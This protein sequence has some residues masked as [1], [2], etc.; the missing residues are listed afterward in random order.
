MRL[1]QLWFRRLWIRAATPLA[2]AEFVALQPTIH[3]HLVQ[4]VSTVIL[5]TETLQQKRE[6]EVAAQGM[7]LI[8]GRDDIRVCVHRSC[9]SCYLPLRRHC[10]A[11]RR[12]ALAARGA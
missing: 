3:S 4:M 10:A 7:L 11:D 6:G 8:K 9:R 12:P 1:R 5:R 2:A